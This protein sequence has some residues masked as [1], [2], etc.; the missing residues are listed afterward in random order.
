MLGFKVCIFNLSFW[1]EEFQEKKMTNLISPHILK[2]K[3]KNGFGGGTCHIQ[4][5]MVCN[6]NKCLKQKK[7]KIVLG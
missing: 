5:N 6:K 4:A 2:R 7:K 1:F 3:C